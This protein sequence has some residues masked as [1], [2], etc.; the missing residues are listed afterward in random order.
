MTG[1]IFCTLILVFS[2]LWCQSQEIHI[3]GYVKEAETDMGLMAVNILDLTSQRGTTTNEDGYY[4][5]TLPAGHGKLV[6]SYVGYNRD[7]IIWSARNDTVIHMKMVKSLTL[8]TVTV[9]SDRRESMED[10]IQMSQ[11]EIQASEIKQIPSLLGE[12]DVLKSL[13]LLPGVQ[14]GMEGTAGIF[15]RGG[16]ID[17]NLILVD[18]VPIYNPTHV[19]GIFSTFNADAIDNV[20][21]TKGGFPAR[22]GG[23][24]SSVVEVNLREGDLEEFHGAGQIGL[25]SSKLLLEGPIIPNKSSFLVSA[26]RSYTD[27]IARPIIKMTRSGSDNSVLPAAYFHDVN[28]K[29]LHRFNDKNRLEFSGYMGADNYGVQR[30]DSI[31]TTNASVNWGNYLGTLTWTHMLT[32]RIITNASII[33]SRYRLDNDIEYTFSKKDIRD[34]FN[35]L[36]HSGIDDIGIKYAMDFVPGSRHA[37]RLGM[38]WTYHRYTPG[39]LTY[40]YKLEEEQV[41]VDF[42]QQGMTSQERN[43]FLEDEMEYG[44]LKLNAGFHFSQFFTNGKL[45]FSF[46]PRL[47]TRINLP[48][49][50]A[51]K[52][53][54]AQME[55]YINLL[56]SESLSL[57]S[58]LW[59]PST[60]RIEPQSSWQAA[61]GIARTLWEDFELTLEGYYKEMENVL[62]YQPGVSFIL[63][64]ASTEDWQNKI[65]QGEG[66]AYGGELLFRKNTGRT[67]GWLAYTLSWNDRKFDDINGGKPF[68]FKYDR[69]HDINLVLKHQLNE[70][71]S[72]SSIWIYGSGHAYSIPDTHYPIPGE[73]FGQSGEYAV[74]QRKNNYQMSDYH[75]L[76][77]SISRKNDKKW[78]ET[79]WTFGVYNT[80]FRKNPLYVSQ[81]L[82]GTVKEVAVLPIIPYVTWGFKF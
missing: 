72:F 80:Y 47:S 53:S 22:Y 6:F 2:G 58:D 75:R 17:Q 77:I 3:R 48:G 74:Y 37:I 41:S 16:S 32:P 64:V 24:L 25:I 23:R 45:Y 60:D 1:K 62:S 30:R 10:Q 14:G 8:Q 67:T 18:G 49:G 63:D 21:I 19:L 28:L 56:T 11:N 82:E 12:A 52:A 54:Y 70:R 40:G 61:T 20:S 36:Y 71:W 69:R 33:Y 27:L 29:L 9:Q 81:D 79:F 76:D 15:V 59:V 31:E 43:F 26:R 65:S 44:P 34:Y 39:A 13:Q 42:N 7:T 46:Q 55:Q 73:Y 35:S 5:L 57:P 68:P 38:E 78:G 50:W 4:K 66:Q 51:F